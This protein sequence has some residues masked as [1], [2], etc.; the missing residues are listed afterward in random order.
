[1]RKIGSILL[2]ASAAAAQSLTCD[3]SRYQAQSGLGVT[4]GAGV[5]TVEWDGERGAR[6]QLRLAVKDGQPVVRQIAVR[7]RGGQWAVLGSNLTPEFSVT[8]GVRRISNQQLS[9]LRALG[10]A[11]TPEVIEKEKWNVFWDAPLNVPGREGVNPGLPRK[12]EEIRRGVSQFRITGC[13]VKTDGAR[14]EVSYDGLQLGV[15]AGRLQYT[16]YRGSNLIRQ[17]A[18]GSTQEA[19]VAYKYNAGLKGFSTKDSGRVS[20]LDTS[21]A[22]QKYEFGG[23]VNQDPVALRARNRIAVIESAAGSLAVLPPPHKFFFARE[24]E[25]NLGYVWYRKDS[26]DRFSAGVRQAEREEMY[27]AHGVSDAVWDSRTRQSRQFAMGNFALYNAPPGTWQRMPVY[28]YASPDGPKETHAALLEYTHGDRFAPLPGYQVAIGH[29]HTH[30]NEMLTDAGT[31]DLWPSWLPAFRALGVNIAMMS[32]FHSDSHP[33]DPGPLRLAEQKVYFDGCRRHSDK[34]FLIMPGEEPDAYFGGHYTMLF[35]KPVYWTHVRGPGQPLVEQ[36]G[37][38]GK[39]YHIGSAADELEMLQQEGGLVWQA[40]PR[41]KGSTYHPDAIRETAYF[42]S[43]RYL[44]ASYQSLPVDLSEQRLCEKR[45]FSTL[46]DMNNWGDP[47]F[48]LAEGD[49]YAKFPEDE[50]YTA[51]IVNYVKLDRLPGFDEDWSPILGALRTGNFFVTTGEILIKTS[52]VEGTGAQRKMTAELEW[53][54]PL[55]FVEL[56]WGD[57]KSVDRQVIPATSQPPF[58]KHRFEIPFDASGKKWVRFAAWDSAGNGAFSQP[59]HMRGA[60]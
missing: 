38:R 33:K 41:T 28:F 50:I 16:A 39:V 10:V 29:F 55:E 47:K 35:P 52:G 4:Q 42:R 8:T 59:V 24:I 27:R 21:R 26:A 36:Q 3:M 43:Q 11:L 6:V 48:M 9:P 18:I 15:F 60:K 53:T 23:S 25:L 58:G 37:E 30:F 57:G 31:I 54:F 46:D 49:T 22:W 56:V 20:W 14:I 17:E 32:D 34:E 7:K 40:H 2:L 51:L 19:S 1:M 45:C 13:A 12:A 5:L 44:G